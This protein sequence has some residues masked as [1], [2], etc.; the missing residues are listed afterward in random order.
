MG[1]HVLLI[2]NLFEVYN[3]GLMNGPLWSLGLEE[4]LYAFYMVFI[5]LRS[6]MQLRYIVLV[7]FLLSQSWN[8]AICSTQVTSSLREFGP[9]APFSLGE[10]GAWPFG[11]WFIWVLG[12]VCAEAYLGNFVMPRWLASWQSI[13]GFGCAW[14][15][16]AIVQR[17]ID[18]ICASIDSAFV[19]RSVHY[20]IAFTE[21]MAALATVC[22]IN[23]CI[24]REARGDAGNRAVSLMAAVGVM[25]YSLYLTHIPVMR[26]GELV[27]SFG[28]G[29]ESAC[30]RI[31]LY[32]PLTLGF[33]YG[34]FMVVERRFL[35]QSASALPVREKKEPV[36][37]PAVLDG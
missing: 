28:H 11:Y 21:P 2:H 29:W 15:T 3:Q 27:F 32:I 18:F 31:V 4:Q 1:V 22:I 20:M 14:L 24:A 26:I 12:A 7:T 30:W 19:K 35:R 25:S 23:C 8:L 33:A 9:P 5:F 13:F 37:R 36:L 17:N 6:R 16:L 34:F 10:W